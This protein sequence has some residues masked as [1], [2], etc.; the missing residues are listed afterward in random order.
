[1]AKRARGWCK[2]EHGGAEDTFLSRFSERKSRESRAACV[3]APGYNSFRYYCIS[4]CRT[5]RDR[6]REAAVN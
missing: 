3:T 5:C 1:M 6:G 2:R 4:S